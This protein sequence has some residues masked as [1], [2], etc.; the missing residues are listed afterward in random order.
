MRIPAAISCAS[1][2]LRYAN[3]R[4]SSFGKS[5]VTLTSLVR[6]TS[7]CA[8]CARR[9]RD[10]PARPRS[11]GSRSAARPRSHRRDERYD[12]GTSRPSFGCWSSVAAASTVSGWSCSAAPCAPSPS[13]G[14]PRSSARSAAASCRGSPGRGAPAPAPAASRPSWSFRNAASVVP[15]NVFIDVGDLRRDLDVEDAACTSCSTCAAARAASRPR[16]RATAPR[17]APARSAAAGSSRRPPAWKASV[18]AA[19]SSAGSSNVVSSSSETRRTVSSTVCGD[20]L[21]REPRA[22]RLRLGRRLEREHPQTRVDDRLRELHRQR[23]AGCTCPT[24]CVE[25]LRRACR[26]RVLRPMIPITVRAIGSTAI[27][28]GMNCSSACS[29]VDARARAR[30]R[31]ARAPRAAARRRRR[32]RARRADGRLAERR[33]P[34]RSRRRR[35]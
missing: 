9:D 11:R 1:A 34:A 20:R 24:S 21:V 28:A 7:A 10:R 14:T 23:P 22:A 35:T 16:P 33:P 27:T 13:P 26:R 3:T 4:N 32:P 5:S 17:A 8:P 19:S 2:S 18:T 25:E 6:R 30:R 31:T 29:R 12:P 15:P